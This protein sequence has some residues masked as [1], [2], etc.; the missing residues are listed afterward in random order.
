MKKYY[1]I[2]AV[3]SLV[4]LA[5]LPIHYHLIQSSGNAETLNMVFGVPIGVLTAVNLNL[6]FNKI[7]RKKK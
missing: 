5:M 4:A 3:L 7:N 1:A 6:I 2:S